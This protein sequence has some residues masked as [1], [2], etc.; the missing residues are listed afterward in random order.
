MAIG[1]SKRIIPQQINKQM[2]K[3]N[4]Q[5]NQKSIRSKILM[6]VVFLCLGILHSGY[7]QKTY[8]YSG[9]VTD[10][11]GETMPGVNVTIKGT[12]SGASTDLNGAFSLTS[13]KPTEVLVFTFVGAETVEVTSAAGIKVNV[14]MKN[15]SIGLQEVVVVG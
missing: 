15:K 5:P 1:K 11:T 7:A 2:R 9:V 13:A 14:S 4:N 10:E 3:L 8:T 12:N 6:L